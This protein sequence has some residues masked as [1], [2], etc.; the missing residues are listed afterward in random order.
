MIKQYLMENGRVYEIVGRDDF[1]RHVCRL[2]ELTE[3]PKDEPLKKPV[4]EEVTEEPE[5]PKRTRKK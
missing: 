1:G 2:T 4:V 5:K 3:I